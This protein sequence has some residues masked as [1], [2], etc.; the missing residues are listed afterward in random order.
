MLWDLEYNHVTNFAHQ[1]NRG[2][3]KS[4]FETILGTAQMLNSDGFWVGFLKRPENYAICFRVTPWSSASIAAF[5]SILW[6][7]Q[8]HL[9]SGLTFGKP[10]SRKRLK[11]RLFLMSP[12]T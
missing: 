9:T 2:C 11:F 1:I 12:N 5:L 7:S 8:S 10:R 6:A 3:P 4:T